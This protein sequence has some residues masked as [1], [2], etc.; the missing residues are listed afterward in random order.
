MSI[1]VRSELPAG[2]S[3][4]VHRR[5]S[6]VHVGH[7][8]LTDLRVSGCR[9]NAVSLREETTQALVI[10]GPENVLVGDRDVERRFKI[11]DELD[12]GD[13]IPTPGSRGRRLR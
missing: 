9:A 4:P 12:V 5:R 3:R 2:H 11:R 10:P 13:G 6:S 8:N 1:E 7:H